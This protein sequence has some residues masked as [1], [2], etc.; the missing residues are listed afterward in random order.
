MALCCERKK[1]E[2]EKT[3]EKG[4]WFGFFD[5][6]LV[7]WVLREKERTRFWFVGYYGVSGTEVEREVPE[8]KG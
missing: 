5:S 7:V 6:C 8:R 1:E 4:S 3:P 2:G